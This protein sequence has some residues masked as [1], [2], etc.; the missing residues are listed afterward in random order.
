MRKTSI[1][2]ENVSGKDNNTLQHTGPTKGWNARLQPP[3]P[4]KQNLKN[5]DFID[6]MIDIKG[7]T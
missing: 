5:T 2:P 6:M 3:S 1:A 7:F 4:Q